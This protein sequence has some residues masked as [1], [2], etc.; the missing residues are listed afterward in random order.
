[1]ID[2]ELIKLRYEHSVTGNFKRRAMGRGSQ[3]TFIAC[4]VSGVGRKSNEL[5]VKMS[6]TSTLKLTIDSG[7]MHLQ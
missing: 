7:A 6:D 3:L 5:R 4:A 1:M 2:D